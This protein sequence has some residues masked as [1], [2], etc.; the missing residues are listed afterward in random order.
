MRVLFKKLNN[1]GTSLIAVII[2][3]GFIGVL[4]SLMLAMGVM[5]YQMK[6]VEAEAKENQYDTETVLNQVCSGLQ[7]VSEDKLEEAYTFVLTRYSATPENERTELVQEKYVDFMESFLKQN[8]DAEETAGY[9]VSPDGQEKTL[10]LT[11]KQRTALIGWLNSIKDTDNAGF[12]Q[13]NGNTNIVFRQNKGDKE[14]DY[15]VILT[16]ITVGYKSAGYS[17][18]ITTDIKL[19][20]PSVGF[21][22]VSGTPTSNNLAAYGVIAD[23]TLTSQTTS[24]IYGNV[25]AGQKILADSGADLGIEAEKVL[26]RGMLETRGGAELSIEG[27]KNGKKCELWADNI[28]TTKAAGTLDNAVAKKQIFIDG[29]CN[30]ANDL[31]MNNPIG[32]VQ[33]KGEYYGYGLIEGMKSVT[34]GSS[35][36]IN[37]P[38]A[39]LDLSDLQKLHLAGR[40]AISV[41]TTDSQGQNSSVTPVMQGEAISYLWTQ[42]AYL[43]PGDCLPGVGHNPM[44]LDE[45][46]NVFLQLTGAEK[47]N[48]TRYVPIALRKYLNP[49]NPY[50]AVFV[51]HSIGDQETGIMVYLYM[52]FM[53]PNYASTYFQEY[54]RDT[55]NK[56]DME[57][58]AALLGFKGIMLNHNIA[59][60]DGSDDK[61]QVSGNIINYKEGSV[62]PEGLIN[63]FGDM[64][65]SSGAVHTSNVFSNIAINKTYTR[66]GLVSYLDENKK[67]AN[68]TTTL[69]NNLINVKMLKTNPLEEKNI[70]AKKGNVRITSPFTGIII[71]DGDVD[72]N[73]EVNGLVIA[74]GSIHIND[75]TI[76]ADSN[77][78][79]TLMDIGIDLQKYFK[80]DLGQGGFAD[81][82]ADDDTET[83]HFDRI[84]ISFENWRKA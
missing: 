12:V 22:T 63:E 51:K 73:A 76:N 72:I 44:T 9:S 62:T 41:E 14:N 5:G 13:N 25:Y 7:E 70:I 11:A 83:E 30:I 36:A 4:G 57:A 6:V 40:T 84:T 56:T 33:L 79:S 42:N 37:A 75:A 21:G 71:V 74:T 28:K 77:V 24:S 58:M 38:K 64:E 50:T 32:N 19:K 61:L 59:A 43:L 55:F 54:A 69:V 78:F 16:N 60:T 49:V 47:F 17:T 27:T 1:R 18:N 29:I 65:V 34:Y 53:T 20:A 45:Y 82:P 39:S 67:I 68:P 31:I 2:A 46:N 3:M 8:A 81:Q 52:N 80:E 15:S 23:N 26:S 35:I 48:I 10:L 66:N